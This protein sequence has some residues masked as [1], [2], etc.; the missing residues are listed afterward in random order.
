MT[1]VDDLLERTRNRRLPDPDIRRLLRTRSGLT[2]AEIANAIGVQRPTVSR[3]ESGLR[4][5]RGRHADAYSQL[6]RGLAAEVA[7]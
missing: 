5:P 1:N 4:T 7:P 2:Q 3:W 6:L